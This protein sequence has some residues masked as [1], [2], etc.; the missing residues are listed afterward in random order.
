MMPPA[1]IP[2]EQALCRSCGFCCD[3][4]LFAWAPLKAGEKDLAGVEAVPGAAEGQFQFRL[5]CPHHRDGVCR[6]YQAVRPDI[7]AAF[8]C[9]LLHRYD[10]GGLSFEQA[11]LVIKET[12]SLAD[13]AR[14]FLDGGA[15]RNLEALF[16]AW[17]EAQIKTGSESWKK[18]HRAF[19]LD[20]AAL[21]WRLTRHFQKGNKIMPQ[22]ETPPAGGG[23]KSPLCAEEARS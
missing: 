9:K 8:K 10:R 18:E 2:P 14:T 11:A 5:P 15:S 1:E 3:G 23:D 12:R 4:T 22:M 7:C 20:Y 6:V 16:A 17:E 13:R 19:L 21:R